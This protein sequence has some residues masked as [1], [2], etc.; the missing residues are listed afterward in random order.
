[1]DQSAVGE[2]AEGCVWNALTIQSGGDLH[3]F[4]PVLDLGVDGVIHRISDG[5]YIDLQVKCRS[6]IEPDG[7]ARLVVWEES[8]RNPVAR[9]LCVD[10]E[11][12]ALAPYLVLTTEAEFAARAHR[13]HN[14]ERSVWASHF[15]PAGPRAGDPWNDR[16]VRA[17]ELAQRLGAAPRPV[18][19]G[20]EPEPWFRRDHRGL[21]A[22]A[23][24][25]LRRRLLER[26]ALELYQPRVDREPVE[27][28]LRRPPGRH[29]GV[30]VKCVG[31]GPAEPA[32]TVA[33]RR[34]SW[35]PAQDLVAVVLAW[36]RETARFGPECLLIPSLEVEGLCRLEGDEMRFDYRPEGSGRLERYRLPLEALTARLDG[37]LSAP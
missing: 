17:A 7:A 4:T 37:L 6:G 13:S 32:A 11:G 8:L 35:R 31:V 18:L 12:E 10:L 2:A 15:H 1:M 20:P 29:L 23:E 24:A 25:E 22:L 34:S 26:E 27:L 16:L 14:G 3:T 5:A 21:G 19:S 33:F 30:Q 9:M 36:G 28:V